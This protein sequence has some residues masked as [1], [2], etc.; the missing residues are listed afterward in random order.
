MLI[1]V[2]VKTKSKKEGVSKISEDTFLVSVKEKP[3]EGLANKRVVEVLREYLKVYNKKV[4]I[5]SG[6][7]SPSKII[8]IE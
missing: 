6:H 5:V 2:K 8:S 1:K 3:E 7:H 4:R